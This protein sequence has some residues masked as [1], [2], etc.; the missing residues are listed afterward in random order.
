MSPG[1]LIRVRPY[2]LCNLKQAMEPP[3]PL[4]F[5]SVKELL[6]F[7]LMGMW[8]LLL[9]SEAE[10]WVCGFMTLYGLQNKGTI[11]E[12]LGEELVSMCIWRGQI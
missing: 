9:G 6:S 3:R 11:N 1:V 2:E 5:T 12:V 8:Y 10:T 4:V 7:C